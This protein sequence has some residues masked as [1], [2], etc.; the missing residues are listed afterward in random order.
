MDLLETSFVVERLPAFLRSRAQRLRKTPKLFFS[1]SG[2]AAHLGSIEDIS[3]R[4]AEPM[5]GHLWETWVFENLRGLVD[6]FLPGGEIG[7]WSIQGRTEVDFV[8]SYK[9]QAIGIEVKSSSSFGKS[10]L[11][12]LRSFV[13]Q[14]AGAAAGVLAYNGEQTLDLGNRVYAIPLPLL[15]S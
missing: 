1:D 6:G 3:I 7:Y 2:L 10:D 5:R 14:T 11:K 4:A 8:V 9:R 13:E 15:L 12:G